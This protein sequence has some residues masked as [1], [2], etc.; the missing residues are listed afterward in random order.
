MTLDHIGLVTHPWADVVSE[1]NI[2]S[3]DVHVWAAL[4]CARNI[5]TQR[6][7][8]TSTLAS[9]FDY[10]ATRKLISSSPSAAVFMAE[11]QQKSSESTG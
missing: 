9:E 1:R 11:Q 10:Q 7:A 2:G 8:A 3:K 6:P 4:K 5:F